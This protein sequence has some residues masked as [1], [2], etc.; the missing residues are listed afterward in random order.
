VWGTSFSSALVAG[1]ASLMISN[2]SNMTPRVLQKALDAGSPIDREM[3]IGRARLHL[4][5]SLLY[6]LNPGN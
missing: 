4:L 1:G 5:R 6:L 3:E 2:S